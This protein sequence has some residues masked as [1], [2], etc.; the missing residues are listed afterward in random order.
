MPTIRDFLLSHYKDEQGFKKGYG[1]DPT[2]INGSFAHMND[3]INQ[4]Y[5]KVFENMYLPSGITLD[6]G[7]KRDF[8]KRFYNKFIEHEVFAQFFTALEDCLCTDCYTMLRLYTEIR[9][10]PIDDMLDNIEVKNDTDSEYTAKTGNLG[11]FANQP[12]TDLAIIYP[13]EDGGVIRY[14]DTLQENYGNSTAGS[15]GN[16]GTRGRN[17]SMSK[18]ELMNYLA[19]IPDIQMRIFNIIETR[20]FSKVFES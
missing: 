12:K 18:F 5:E 19:Q 13:A 11:I 6:G 8:C 15:K 4:T 1:T 14:A 16:S 2:D 3:V 17:T 9:N 10:M 7:F 20:C